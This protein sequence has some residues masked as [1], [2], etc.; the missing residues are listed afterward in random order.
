V[1]CAATCHDPPPATVWQSIE[2]D[3]RVQSFMFV[4]DGPTFDASLMRDQ[5][6]LGFTGVLE[7]GGDGVKYCFVQVFY[8][9]KRF[10]CKLLEFANDYNKLAGAGKRIRVKKM[11]GF[12]FMIPTGQ[13]QSN[14]VERQWIKDMDTRPADLQRWMNAPPK[15]SNSSA[16]FRPVIPARV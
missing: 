10:S 7:N 12:P 5:I 2:H 3:L 11:V 4:Y 6:D 13:F 14:P 15:R 9:H 16:I 8:A 1:T